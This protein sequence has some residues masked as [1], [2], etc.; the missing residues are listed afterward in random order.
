MYTH[1]VSLLGWRGLVF[2]RV[3][4]GSPRCRSGKLYTAAMSVGL[5]R[6]RSAN[7]CVCGTVVCV[8]V[9]V[10]VCVWTVGQGWRRAGVRLVA[11]DP[12][13]GLQTKV[14]RWSLLFLCPASGDL[15]CN[16]L[17]MAL[18]L[19]LQ[20][21]SC[22]SCSHMSGPAFCLPIRNDTDTVQTSH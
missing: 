4:K 18:G 5:H 20:L 16:L 1:I 17:M 15:I 10:C 6:G 7:P 12:N 2:F 22:C 13:G 14:G 3:W 9:C 11:R 21:L 19:L 8:C